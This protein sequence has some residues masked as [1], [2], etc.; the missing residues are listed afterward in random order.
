MQGTQHE[1]DVSTSQMIY[2]CGGEP[3]IV[4]KHSFKI[5]GIWP[6]ASTHFRKCSPNSVG[7]I[8]ARP[9]YGSSVLSY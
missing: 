8:Q 6:Q 2:H 1:W 7:L 3:E 4:K 9:N 5:Y